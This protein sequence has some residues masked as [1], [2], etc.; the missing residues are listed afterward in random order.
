M[1]R[2]IAIH[3]HC[4]VIRGA[5]SALRV[6]KLVKWA[7]QSGFVQPRRADGGGDST[8]LARHRWR[9]LIDS[10][11]S[12]PATGTPRYGFCRVCTCSV[13]VNVWAH[14]DYCDAGDV[15]PGGTGALPH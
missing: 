15:D 4:A 7:E 8:E 5:A 14:C 11:A 12:D 9:Y 1:P 3:P 13:H 10:S 6:R 2:E